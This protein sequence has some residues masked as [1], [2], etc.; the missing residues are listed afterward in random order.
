MGAIETMML[1]CANAEV[2]RRL[3]LPTQGYI[4]LS[5]AKALDA[6]AGLE[7]GM[8]A[9][10]AGLSGINSVSGPGMLDFESCQSLSKLVV[11]DEICGMVARLRRG[12]EP[13]EDFPSRPLFEELLREG[14]LLI[15]AH[16][17]RHLKEQVR[18]PGPVIERAPLGRWREEGETTLGQRA[19]REVERL[20]AAWA[21]SRVGDETK[22]ALRE[23]LSAAARAAGLLALPPIEA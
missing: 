9:L 23:R 20:L 16:T 1:D 21:P 13:R 3:S 8:G 6:Q 12:I 22:K 7:T 14:H 10:L 11:D 4:G 2:G 17:R 18:F 5:D 15:A 19:R